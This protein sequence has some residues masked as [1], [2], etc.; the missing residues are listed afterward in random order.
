MASSR[1]APGPLGEPVLQRG[2]LAVLLQ[3]LERGLADVDDGQPVKVAGL[4]PARQRQVGSALRRRPHGPPPLPAPGV[5]SAAGAAAPGGRS[6]RPAS[7]AS[8]RV[9]RTKAG[10]PRGG[11][12]L[13]RHTAIQRA[14]ASSASALAITSQSTS[15]AEVPRAGFDQA[16]AVVDQD[17]H[18][19]ATPGTE[20][21]DLARERVGAERLLHQGR[22]A[23]HALA[24]VDRPRRQE[25]AYPRRDR[26]HGSPRTASSTRRSAAPSTSA[27]TRTTAG[28]S[29][30]SI[31][32]PGSA[33][34]V[35][36]SVTSTGTNPGASRAAEAASRCRQ[37]NSW[38][39]CSP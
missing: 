29:T 9:A 26:D 8:S 30:I 12:A 22:Q 32:P 23:V 39:G 18:P 34:A 27:P 20:D 1:I 19:I 4:D 15:F 25:D 11:L 7:G 13:P 36:S 10:S 2:R 33:G 21:E 35:P 14:S 37:T 31:R 28:P 3:L 16:G 24:E 38:L 6:G 5:P 17:L